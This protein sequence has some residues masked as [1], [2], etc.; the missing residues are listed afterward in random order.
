MLESE[1]EGALDDSWVWVFSPLSAA[2][3]APLMFALLKPDIIDLFGLDSRKP[4]VTEE[5]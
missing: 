4:K 1:D 3:I 2:I 5:G